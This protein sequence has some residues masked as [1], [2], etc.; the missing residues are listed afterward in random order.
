M[1]KLFKFAGT[2]YLKSEPT[3]Q[4]CNYLNLDH[5]Y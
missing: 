2:E 3:Y 5:S 4:K 1:H